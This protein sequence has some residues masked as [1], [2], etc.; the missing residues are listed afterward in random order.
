MRA[1]EL[2]PWQ[3]NEGSLN[4]RIRF[5]DGVVEIDNRSYSLNAPTR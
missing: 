5:A 2:T 4:L 1:M 3:R